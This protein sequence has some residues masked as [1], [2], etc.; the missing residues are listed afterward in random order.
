[1]ALT[2]RCPNPECGKSYSV[3]ESHLGR[4]VVCRACGRRFTLSRSGQE[5]KSS[6]A[7]LDTGQAA[8]APS[9]GA[10]PQRL[11]R[12]EIR[13]R[14]G[15]G[16]FGVVYRAYDPVL[17][18]E[19]A[20]KAPHQSTLKSEKDKERFL[21]EAKAAGKLRHPNIVPVY[22]AG[23][24]GDTYYIASAFIQG[25]TLRDAMDA[26][27]FDFAQ[28]IRIVQDLARA[29]DYAHGQ[30]I[31][32]RDVK[33]ANI[34]LD[35]RG[36]PLITDFG[37]ARQWE[38]EEDDTNDDMDL[39]LPAEIPAE[40]PC[41]DP[42]RTAFGQEFAEQGKDDLTQDGTVLGTPAYMSPEQAGGQHNLVGPVS[43]QYALGVV[44]YELLCGVPPFSGPPGLVISLVL[45]QEPPPPS[46]VNPQVPKDLEKICLKAMSKE[47]LARYAS[48]RE[49]ADDL[50]RW[51][52]GEPI[53]PEPLSDL[54]RFWQWCRRNPVVAGLAAA[55]V[56]A[57]LIGII[58][59]CCLGLVAYR[60]TRVAREAK[61]RAEEALRSE[62]TTRE[63]EA[64][65]RKQAESDLD[66]AEAGR[67]RAEEQR[68]SAEK[69]KSRAGKAEQ[70]EYEFRFCEACEYW[71]SKRFPEAEQTLDAIPPQFRGCEWA[72]LKRL[73]SPEQRGVT[74]RTG[75]ARWTCWAGSLDGN[76]FAAG[77]SDRTVRIWDTTTGKETLRLPGLA[78]DVPCVA[79]SPDG[80]RIATASAGGALTVWEATGGREAIT[81]SGHGD[82][83]LAVAF[84]PDGQHIVSGSKDQTVKVWDLATGK[85]SQTLRGHEGSV[86]CVAFSPDGRQIL[87]GSM[88]KTI[89]V[90]DARTGQES[91]CIAAHAEA[92]STVAWSHDG[93]RI[94][95][96]S[97]DY[98]IKVWD[99]ASGRETL[100]RRRHTGR[101]S[102]AAFSPDG[103][104]IISVSDDGTLRVWSALSGQELLTF[105]GEGEGEAGM[106][107]S[108]DGRWI[109]SGSEDNAITIWE[110]TTGQEDP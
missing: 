60:H 105:R 24:D 25:T 59:P 68:T 5:T 85:E 46:S 43:D 76:L 75:D 7:E 12:F 37:L 74:L 10:V 51:Q 1:M 78:D 34:M 81:L 56:S 11:G 98:R 20:L 87:S 97:Q 52:E 54:G 9:P 92:V 23:V 32:H 96:G 16:A 35:A 77:C 38:I 28:S 8:V 33:P 48:C 55:V 6:A 31:L 103:R 3:R 29:L 21:R 73:C 27:R 58:V 64:A 108:P 72:Y 53:H 41:E 89:R 14:L 50:R 109:A 44:L 91:R 100:M 4:A 101:V 45:N 18:R 82:A 39:G 99:A 67:T 106:A 47:R 90:W 63:Q 107:F 84:G 19:V 95:S 66:L 93:A 30:G 57:L 61:Q 40:L 110:A 36:D 104:R 86:A 2:A 79:F 62:A 65:A 49:L 102:L 69:A 83:V 13:S 15:A 26:N 17:D 70:K 22:E 71:A 94:L 80:K 42:I 88:D